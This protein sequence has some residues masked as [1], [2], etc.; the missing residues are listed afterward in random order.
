MKNSVRKPS[1]VWKSLKVVLII[2]AAF[3]LGYA[4]RTVT[5][6]AAPVAEHEHVAQTDGDQ[7]QW[8][9]CSMHPQI[10]QPK[11]G[12][13]PICFMDLIPVASSGADVGE[14]QI[15]FSQAAV[16][17]M[18]IATTP[19]E[20]KF[21]TA[22]V[23][24]VGKID[25][26]EAQVKNITAWVPGRIDRLY[27]DFT[28][29]TVG[30]GDH[31]VEL[32]S[33]EL[34]S[35]EAELLQA[36]KAADNVKTATSE[37]VTRTTLATLEAAREKLRLLGLTVEQISDIESSGRTVTHITIYS[38]I[39][40]IV[41]HKNATEGVY[42][43]TGTPIYTVADLSRL[44]VK[45]DAYESDLSWIRYGQK[46]EFTTEAYPGEV[47]EGTINFIDPVLN[48]M[49]RT[50][51]LRVNVDNMD[52]KLKPEMF[53]RAVVR[54]QVALGGK[55]MVP[56][57][58]GK[59][60]CPMHPAVVKTEAGTCDVC[61]MNLV[62]TESLGYVVDTPK[63]APLV[64]PASAPL[65]TGT[66]A[67]VYVQVPQKEK[68]TFEGRQ[69]TL[70]P[71]A[72][73]YYLVKEGL[74]EGE[75]V[76]TKGNFK[77]DASLQIQAK[78]SMMN[79]AAGQE[80]VP[81][82][83]EVPAA[84]REQVWGVV[85]KYLS[86]HHALAGDDK[87]GAIKAAPSAIQAIEQVDMS[88]LSGKPH[89]VWMGSVAGMNKALGAIKESVQIEAARQGFEQLSNEL[90]AVVRKFGVAENRVLYRLHCPMAFNNKGAD[91]LQSDADTLNPYFGAAM[92]KCGEV[93]EVI[94][95]KTK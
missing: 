79:P 25:Y 70:G 9:T 42:V 31:M 73:D 80:Q 53:V 78:P 8:W 19:V 77:I 56:E 48:D 54:S 95:V 45:L 37:L 92:L 22:D 69:V 12:K 39:G 72:G 64:I 47:F 62:A 44:W 91:W 61:G 18:E 55:V 58:A 41:I 85:E 14:R 30:K 76:V 1:F 17:L 38:P 13:C 7:Q 29:I 33:P 68:P 21:V 66:R 60:I 27:V 90:I 11:P 49:T 34:I 24:M 67:V 32:Y 59:W 43:D 3:V 4:A 20:R 57:M 84:F 82:T 86:L 26:D 94:G 63:E 6:P 16:K 35:A 2:I 89:E 52:G 75:L 40:G 10:R 28:G 51:K 83:L 65:V 87:D 81:E 15:S 88:L 23:R 74:S 36:L 71:R 46:V 5:G 93:A 50:V